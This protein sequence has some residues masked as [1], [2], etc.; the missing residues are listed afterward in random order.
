[1][2]WRVPLCWGLPSFPAP[3]PWQTAVGSLLASSLHPLRGVEGM[4]LEARCLPTITPGV[5][6][7]ALSIEVASYAVWSFAGV[8]RG[9]LA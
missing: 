3:P 7:V 2:E 6:V 9:A 5:Q 8:R 4:L 1:M